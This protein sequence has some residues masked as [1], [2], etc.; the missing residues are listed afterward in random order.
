MHHAVQCAEPQWSSCFCVDAEGSRR[1][2]RAFLERYAGTPALIMPA[3]FPTPSVGR[4]APAGNAFRF[5]FV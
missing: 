1:T 4:I 5:D 3:H 2:R